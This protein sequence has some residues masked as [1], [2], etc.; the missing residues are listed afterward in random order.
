MSPLLALWLATI[1]LTSSAAGS[2]VLER[3]RAAYTKHCLE[4]HGETGRGDGP[5]A[6]KLRFRARD[7]APGSFKCRSTPTG[8]V[9]TDDDLR[10]TVRDGLG[11]TPMTGFADILTAADIDSVI[12]YIKQF[13]PR[14]AATS[15]PEVVAVPEAPPA[16]PDLVTAG[17]EIYR[18]LQCW[19]CHG[20]SGRGDGP[21]A[22]GLEDDWG[23]RAKPGRFGVTGRLKCGGG[24]AEL[25][26]TIHTGLDGTPMPSYAEALRFGREAGDDLRAMT[27]GLGADAAKDVAAWLA[28]E[29][30]AATIAAMSEAEQARLVERR[31][32]ALVRYMLSLPGSP[33]R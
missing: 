24:E 15:A 31:T 28:T 17:R 21:A 6:Q 33:R 26:R 10:R 32:W 30:D 29:P 22:D 23:A 18:V 3:G 13:S 14:F 8:S 7:F 5:T 9:P 16:D 4:C 1:T 27:R 12:A 11:G 19:T 25:Y 20:S 2:E